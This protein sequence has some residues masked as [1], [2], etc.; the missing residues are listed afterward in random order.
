MR[1][2]RRL[3]HNELEAVQSLVGNMVFVCAFFLPDGLLRLR[4]DERGNY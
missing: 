4:H 1:F 2:R 3:L